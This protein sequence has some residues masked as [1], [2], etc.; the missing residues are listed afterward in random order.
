MCLSLY[1]NVNLY[2][3]GI[4]LVEHKQ[5]YMDLVV[6]LVLVGLYAPIVEHPIRVKSSSSDMGLR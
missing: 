1:F 5:D 2:V 3:S 6:L 4:F